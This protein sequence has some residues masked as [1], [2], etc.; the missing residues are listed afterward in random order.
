VNPAVV[1]WESV[2]AIG[3]PVAERD[4]LAPIT[5]PHGV[6]RARQGS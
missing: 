5:G 4:Q 1:D 3:G 6:T 2:T